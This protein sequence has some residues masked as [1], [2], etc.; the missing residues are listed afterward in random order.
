MINYNQDILVVKNSIDVEQQN[1]LLKFVT[2]HKFPW[3]FYP[4]TILPSDV[5][6]TNDCIVEKGINPPQF[7]HYMT[8]DES[9]NKDL[10]SPILN[11][12]TSVVNNNIQILKLKF[13]LLTKYNKSTHHWPHSDI[14]DYDFKIM[15]GLYYVNTSDGPTYFF[16]K[17]A[18]KKSNSL[19]AV[20]K[21]DPEQG[22]LVIF[23]SRRFHASSSPVVNEKRI[24]L[25]VVF[26]IPNDE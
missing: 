15:T 11:C 23:D 10:L 24:V 5:Q 8:I 2:D 20:V 17:F 26:R 9:Q 25:N 6:Y 1:T 3:F 12:I 4:G 18:P 21:I 14:D 16:N 22:K 13:N 19:K 7:S